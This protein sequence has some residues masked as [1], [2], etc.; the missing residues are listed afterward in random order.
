MAIQ[1]LT[2]FKFLVFAFEYG[3]VIFRK[4]VSLI[5]VSQHIVLNFDVHLD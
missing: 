1:N 3:W 4:A 2:W 5:V